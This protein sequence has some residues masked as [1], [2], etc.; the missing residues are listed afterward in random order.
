M[1]VKRFV[2][3]GGAALL[4]TLVVLGSC[5]PTDNA[6]EARLSNDLLSTVVVVQCVGN[7][8][9]PC[10]E[11]GQETTIGA[12]GSI[13]ASTDSTGVPNPYII[14]RDGHQLGCLPLVF[15]RPRKDALV[16]TYSY[17]SCAPF[18]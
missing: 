4:V 2:L 5:N 13:A 12:G 14:E 10:R 7:G 16:Y 3:V 6:L 15:N 18:R 17:E 8:R 1:S 11:L 9:R